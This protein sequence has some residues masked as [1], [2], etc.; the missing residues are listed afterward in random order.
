MLLAVGQGEQ[1]TPCLAGRGDDR[2]GFGCSIDD[3]LQDFVAPRSLIFSAEVKPRARHWRRRAR[4]WR[5]GIIAD[6][7]VRHEQGIRQFA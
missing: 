3:P 5:S 1:L 4:R 6:R 2:G 7:A